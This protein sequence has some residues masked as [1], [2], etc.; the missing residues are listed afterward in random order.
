MVRVE[1][2]ICLGAKVNL[3]MDFA[4]LGTIADQTKPHVSLALLGLAIALHNAWAI[5]LLYQKFQPT[6]PWNSTV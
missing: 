5:F 1:C 3:E 6:P 2:A 4:E